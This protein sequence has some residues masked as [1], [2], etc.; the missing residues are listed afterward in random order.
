MSTTVKD[1][2]TGKKISIYNALRKGELDTLKRIYEIKEGDLTLFNIL[3]GGLYPFDWAMRRGYYNL[4][5]WFV[6]IGVEPKFDQDSF[7]KIYSDDLKHD[8]RSLDQLL[9][10]PNINLLSVYWKALTPTRFRREQFIKIMN[11]GNTHFLYNKYNYGYI[12][13][14]EGEKDDNS[15]CYNYPD[16]IDARDSFW[17]ALMNIGEDVFQILVELGYDFYPL[18]IL[19]IFS[20]ISYKRYYSLPFKKVMLQSLLKRVESNELTDEEKI[21]VDQSMNKLLYSNY[22]V[23]TKLK[24][25]IKL[26]GDRYDF[27]CS[28]KKS[29]SKYEL[30]IDYSLIEQ[31]VYNNDLVSLKLLLEYN[32]GVITSNRLFSTLFGRFRFLSSDSDV[33]RLFHFLNDNYQEILFCEDDENWDFDYYSDIHYNSHWFSTTFQNF[34]KVIIENCKNEKFLQMLTS[35]HLSK[36]NDEDRREILKFSFAN[37]TTGVNYIEEHILGLQDLVIKNCKSI[38]SGFNCCLTSKSFPL[39]KNVAIVKREYRYS[40]YIP[41]YIKMLNYIKFYQECGYTFSE[42]FLTDPKFEK[43]KNYQKYIEEIISMKEDNNPFLSVDNP[44]A[45]EFV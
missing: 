12:E 13:G 29:V 19:E 9:T 23:S 20:D 30:H 16:G 11:H 28:M 14:V 45:V 42:S 43:I 5:E 15:Y 22:D 33:F 25:L 40:Y 4:I 6:S 21:T 8:F 31:V 26:Y 2:E 44:S 37:I 17:K 34:L 38:I 27:N 18:K 1:P 10:I 39:Y 41:I 24:M 35:I 7:V 36:V 3:H 32:G